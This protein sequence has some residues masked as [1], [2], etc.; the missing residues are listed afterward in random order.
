[1]VVVASVLHASRLANLFSVAPGKSCW[2]ESYQCPQPHDPTLTKCYKGGTYLR[3]WVISAPQ[4]K[5]QIFGDSVTGQ[6]RGSEG[7]IWVTYLHL[8]LLVVWPP[9]WGVIYGAMKTIKT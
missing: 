1:M 5:A 9:I 4:L 3:C 8:P 7:H 6:L 2:K